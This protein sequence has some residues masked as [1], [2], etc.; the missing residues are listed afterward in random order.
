MPL[1][2]WGINSEVVDDWDRESQFQPYK[3]PVPPNGVYQ[4]CVKILKFAAG[5]RDKLPQLRIGL[6][7]VP[8]GADEKKYKDYFIMMFPPIAD[9]TEFR[10]VPFLDAIGVSGKEFTRGTRTDEEGNIRKIG[11]WVNDGKTLILAQLQDG[12]DQNNNPRKEITWVGAV[13][14]DEPADDD[15]YEQSDDEGF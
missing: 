3:G 11:R 2:N 9:N 10:Y 14:A 13:D 12:V 7:L 5:T 1:V 6:S 4:W 8:R 15:D